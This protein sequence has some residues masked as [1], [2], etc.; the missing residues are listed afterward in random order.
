MGIPAGCFCSTGLSDLQLPLDFSG[1]RAACDNCKLLSHVDISET[2]VTEIQEFTFV[3][4]IQLQHVRLPHTIHTTH[5]KPS[6][7][8][9]DGIPTVIMNASPVQTW[10]TVEPPHHPCLPLFLHEWRRCVTSHLSRV[11]MELQTRLR[12]NRER[13]TK[14]HTNQTK[15]NKQKP[16]KPAE[17]PERGQPV[18]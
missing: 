11:E 18:E 10:H 12:P 6:S 14:N 7:M 9:K 3:H 1:L 17:P 15:P 4:C 2:T 16:P 5:P 13:H 8:E